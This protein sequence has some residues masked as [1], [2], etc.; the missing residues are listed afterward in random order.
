M[1]YYHCA[2][3]RKKRF[4]FESHEAKGD[5]YERL[6][7]VLRSFDSKVEDATK[8]VNINNSNNLMTYINDNWSYSNNE[9]FSPLYNSMLQFQSVK[10]GCSDLETV[11]VKDYD[12]FN[13]DKGLL[14]ERRL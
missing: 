4:L 6:D 7:E 2:F 8:G 1:L 13:S 5:E 14:V 3:N 12:N 11:N 10:E 9:E